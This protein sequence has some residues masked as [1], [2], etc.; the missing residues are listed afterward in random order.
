MHWSNICIEGF[1]FA[2]EDSN[3]NAPCGRNTTSHLCI[4]NGHCPHFYY[5]E[6]TERDVA[7]IPKLRLILKDRL[8]TLFGDLWDSIT[9]I[10]WNQLWFN[11]RKTREFFNNIQT[12]SAEDC[13]ALAEFEESQQKASKSF[14]EWFNQ[15][16]L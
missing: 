11:Q 6:T 9:W 7:R 3:G 13:P 12:I 4:E 5:S 15:V 16:Q 8:V 2:D 10:F 1:C 14:V